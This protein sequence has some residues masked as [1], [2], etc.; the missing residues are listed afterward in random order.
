MFLART[1]QHGWTRR[2]MSTSTGGGFHFPSPRSLQSLVKLDDL[3]LETPDAI[4]RIWGE[5]HDAKSDALATVL[6]A[7]ELETLI[8]RGK[9]CSF[10]VFPVYRVNSETKEEGFFTMLSQFQD[11]CFLLTT[12]DAYRENPAQAP[13]CLTV[14]L[15]DDLVPSK[16]LALVRGDVANVL[17]K[18]EAS[19]LLDA[20]LARYVDD[21]LFSTVEAF[22]LKPHEFNFDAYL[23]ECKKKRDD[24]RE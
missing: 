18:P 17:D 10:F 4:R 15:F 12:L 3:Q 19:V 22:N 5:Y 7:A 8:A 13:P 21:D 23:A 11:K 9:K 6:T 2:S 16:E 20:L 1:F 24:S 14:S